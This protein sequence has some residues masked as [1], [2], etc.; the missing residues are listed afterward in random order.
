MEPGAPIT[1]AVHASVF[2]GERIRAT[3]E[4]IRTAIESALLLHT[5]LTIVAVDVTVTDIH[6]RRTGQESS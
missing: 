6:L 4:H 3:A 1:V 5:E 2:G